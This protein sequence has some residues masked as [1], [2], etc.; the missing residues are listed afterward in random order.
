M[1]VY[2]HVSQAGHRMCWYMRDGLAVIAL[3]LPSL[4]VVIGI[5]PPCMFYLSQQCTGKRTGNQE[6]GSHK[7]CGTNFSLVISLSFLVN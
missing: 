5:G 6:P 4:S 1:E 2:L 3:P 7:D